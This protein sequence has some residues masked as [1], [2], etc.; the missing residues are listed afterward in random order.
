M[1]QKTIYL[2]FDGVLH[3]N[4]LQKGQAFCHMPALARALTGKSVGIIVS[5]SWRL[6]ETWE[7]I[8]NLFPPPIRG[9]LAGRTGGAH[10]GRWSRWNEI[11]EHADRH[12]IKDWVALD[13]AQ[14]EFPPECLNLIHCD[15][16]IGLQQLQIDALT[17]WLGRS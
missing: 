11:T 5:S 7:Y 9:C 12:Q 15:G 3:P 17:E 1:A 8:E 10:L 4:I 16:A 14:I 6:H 2:D 13:D